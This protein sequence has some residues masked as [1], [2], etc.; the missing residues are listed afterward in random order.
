M[1]ASTVAAQ[2]LLTL[3]RPGRAGGA[4]LLDAARLAAETG[5]HLTVVV[6]VATPP[7]GRRC[8]GISGGSWRRLMCEVAEEEDVPRALALLGEPPPTTEVVV[9][10]GLTEAAILAAEAQAR[11]CDAIVLPHA[12]RRARRTLQR[13]TTCPVLDLSARAR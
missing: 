5:A 2:H 1:T 3:Y 11:G 13:Q 8:C 10:A 7:S 9:R 4:A 12:A 6:P